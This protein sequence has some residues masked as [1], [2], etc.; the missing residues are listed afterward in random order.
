[1]KIQENNE[2]SRYAKKNTFIQDISLDNIFY[3]I[4]YRKWDSYID[5]IAGANSN[6]LNN[7]HYK[8]DQ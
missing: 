8:R 3:I 7:S 5:C 1:M 6:A 4:E 2:I